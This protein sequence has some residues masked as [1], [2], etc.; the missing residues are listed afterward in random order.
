M[1]TARIADRYAKSLV[2]LS[3]E[4]GLLEE[5][6]ND[7]LS[8]IAFTNQSKEFAYMLKSPIIK[9]DKKLKIV[10]ALSEGRISEMTRA[11]M[12]LLVRKGRERHLKDIMQVVCERYD[13]IKGISRINLTTA[14]PVSDDVKEMLVK[15]LLTE[16]NMTNIQVNTKVDESL[17]GGFVLEYNNYLADR[18]IKRFL[19]EAK[20]QYM[21][22]IPV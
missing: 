5:V 15:K 21:K 13:G 16:T 9:A 1:S 18:S 17:L 3:V 8:I 20:K 22:R 19:N 12:N 6:H 11:F 7:A 4:K 2:D 10:N 14:A